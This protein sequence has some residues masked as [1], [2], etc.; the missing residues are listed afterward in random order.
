MVRDS[1]D[2]EPVA[3][4][5]V[6]VF[7]DGAEAREAVSDRYGAFEV[8]GVRSGSGRIEVAG[9]GYELWTLDYTVLPPD[10]LRVLARR[11]PLEL[12]PVVCRK[13]MDSS[14]CWLWTR[15]WS[16]PAHA[17]FNVAAG[18]APAPLQ[19]PPE[20]P[21]SGSVRGWGVRPFPREPN[22][23]PRRP[24]AGCSPADHRSPPVE[25]AGL[26]GEP[27]VVTGGRSGRRC[28]RF[29]AG[30][31]GLRDGLR[32]SLRRG[33]APY[34]SGSQVGLRPSDPSRENKHL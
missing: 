10:P 33:R 12:D 25:T 17:T 7:A 23:P 14:L 31:P 6:T 13:D 27:C 29:G 9:L 11:S 21:R 20:K 22:T 16:K 26:A 2:L 34:G 24:V 15:Y 18:E 30:P 5:R 1:V 4:A 28:H 19:I 32:P 3:Y 8:A